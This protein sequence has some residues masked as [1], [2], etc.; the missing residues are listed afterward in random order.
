MC[1]TDGQTAD[2]LGRRKL[3]IRNYMFEDAVSLVPESPREVRNE[4]SFVWVEADFL[5][6]FLSLENVLDENFRSPGPL[7]K[8]KHL[9]CEHGQ[10]HPK[11]ARKGKLLP[12]SLYDVYV[13]L[14]RGEQLLLRKQSRLIYD[15]EDEIN[16]CIITPSKN[17]ICDTCS[18]SYRN[19]LKGKLDHLRNIKDLYHFLDSSLDEKPEY[20]HEEENPICP[21]DAFVYIISKKMATLYK[22]A[23]KALMK[24]LAKVEEGAVLDNETLRGSNNS[25]FEGIDSIDLSAFQGD[26]IVTM[27][28]K[29]VKQKKDSGPKEMLDKFFNQSITCKHGNCNSS[30]HTRIRFI[31]WEGWQ[32]VKKVFP[33]AI[34]LTKKR[35]IK[36]TGNPGVDGC[37]E[38][39]MERLSFERLQGDLEKWA[40][41]THEDVELKN[42][43]DGTV[44]R[45]IEA[46]NFKR[47]QSGCRLVHR[48]DIDSWRSTLK[49]LKRKTKLIDSKDLKAFV[50]NIAFPS[51]HSVVLEFE[52]Q[53]IEK[54]VTSLRSLVCREH[55]LVIE[56]AIFFINSEST[57]TKQSHLLSDHIVVLLDEE[58][59]AYISS[60]AGLLRVLNPEEE[61]G[62]EIGSIGSPVLID[63]DKSLLND[64]LRITDSYHPRIKEIRGQEKPED[65]LLLSCDGSTK[66]FVLSPAGVCRCETCKKEF[67][68]LLLPSNN[69][70]DKIES[71]SVDSNESKSDRIKKQEASGSESADPIL[72]E[73]DIDDTFTRG[74]ATFPLRV[75]EVK[76]DSSLQEALDSLKEASALPRENSVLQNQFLRRS[77]RSHKSR[78]PVGCLLSENSVNVGLHHNMAALRLLLYEKCEVGLSGRKLTLV[79]PCVIPPKTCEIK[80]E[81]GQK[82]LHELFDE[83]SGLVDKSEGQQATPSTDL[84]LLYQKESNGQS[85]TFNATVMDSLLQLANLEAGS[86][87]NQAKNK[88]RRRS[89]ERG[90]QGT[91]LHSSLPSTNNHNRYL[92]EAKTPAKSDVSAVSDEEKYAKSTMEDPSPSK[93]ITRFVLSESDNSDDEIL[94]KTLFSPKP[95]NPKEFNHTE[96][97]IEQSESSNGEEENDQLLNRNSIPSGI[98]DGHQVAITIEES[99]EEKLQSDISQSLAMLIGQDVDQSKCWDATVWAI[100]NNGTGTTKSAVLDSAFAKYLSET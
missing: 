59:S 93:K 33:K 75:F 100:K 87:D 82:S 34:E 90:F 67:A 1:F 5:R 54:A 45:E 97:I 65:I 32:K 73:S 74:P 30:N 49:A 6:K 7:L 44:S 89:S 35:T 60:L 13:S 96:M 3:G 8:H 55:R 52:R 21:E 23:V 56:S 11:I 58:Y 24:T 94:K 46:R 88:K 84:L 28:S 38:C 39:N 98:P 50:E 99:E 27:D 40:K 2:R 70:D 66:E 47:A 85:S 72:V 42:L 62:M 16:D 83:M 80:F 25:V 81:W 17:L 68:P 86:T 91:L 76:D 9:L 63:T 48:A 18:Q 61:D 69:D 14:L 53:P 92:P 51:Y 36:V 19:D 22:N 31:S 78:Y 15:K 43:V 12:R 79:L 20:Y 26:F 57:D 71:I 29:R 4:D 37:P 77:S 64:I 41:E 10:L 95:R